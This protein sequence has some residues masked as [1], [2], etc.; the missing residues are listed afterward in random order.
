M[1]VLTTAPRPSFTPPSS[2][3]HTAFLARSQVRSLREQLVA[4]ASAAA[5][6]ALTTARE[7]QA[8][9]DAH[10]GASAEAAAALETALQARQATLETALEAATVRAGALAED[11][12]RLSAEL[13]A[14]KAALV[15]AQSAAEAQQKASTL[16]TSD[17]P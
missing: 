15:A 9:L 8:K 1:H 13:S 3:V 5:A 4:A 14:A 11:V 7:W 17:G 6:A 12:D 2:L 16:M 10:D